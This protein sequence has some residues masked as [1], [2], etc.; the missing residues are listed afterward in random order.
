MA[1]DNEAM[2][3]AGLAV[4]AAATLTMATA[5]CGTSHQ[6]A[7]FTLQMRPAAP[8]PARGCISEARRYGYSARGSESLCAGGEGRSWYHAVLINRGSGAYPACH[9]TALDAIGKP[10]FSGQLPFGFGGVAAGLF[11]PGHRSTRFYWYLPEK[12]R[13]PVARYTAACSPN[14]NPPV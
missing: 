4:V 11:A 14:S 3:W 12:T 13:R 2:K 1:A 9:A 6:S 8:L 5:G 10:V 7:Q